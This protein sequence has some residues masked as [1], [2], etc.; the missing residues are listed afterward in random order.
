MENLKAALSA[1]GVKLYRDDSN[2]ALSRAQMALTGRT[3]CVD[4]GT[5]KYFGARINNCQ[6]DVNGLY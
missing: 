4:P 1:Y 5:M 6:I 3:R 2:Y